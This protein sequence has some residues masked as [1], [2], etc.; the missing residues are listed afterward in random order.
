MGWRIH[1][2]E[3]NLLVPKKAINALFKACD[4]YWYD[5][6]NILN[7]NGFLRLNYDALEHM[8]PVSNPEI[9]EV[10]KKYKAKGSIL[11]GSLDGDNAG[12]FWGYRFANGKME[13]LS[14]NI[15]WQ[16]KADKK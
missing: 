6:E 11:F 13:N 8:D 5:K 7:S 1:C 10:L 2:L 15:H 12:D 16:I 9:Q 3:N 14:G 4:D